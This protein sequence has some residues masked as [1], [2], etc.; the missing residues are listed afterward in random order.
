MRHLPLVAASSLFVYVL[1]WQVLQ[2]MRATPWL[3]VAAGL[4]AGILYWLAW[5]RGP[6]R[7]R[8][9]RDAL[10]ARRQRSGTPVDADAG[11]V[12]APVVA[13]EV[14]RPVTAGAAPAS[15]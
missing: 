10:L 12:A 5:T 14:A 9:L 6:A 1:H 11:A 15:S 2:A 13:R 8:R 7:L 3:S 4:A